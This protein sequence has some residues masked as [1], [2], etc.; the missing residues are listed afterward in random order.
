M[1]A[2]MTNSMAQNSQQ[3]FAECAKWKEKNMAKLLGK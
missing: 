3:R 1:P 2:Q